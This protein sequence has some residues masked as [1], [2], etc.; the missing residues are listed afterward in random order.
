MPLNDGSPKDKSLCVL[1]VVNDYGDVVP[2][3]MMFDPQ[4]VAEA[5]M[6]MT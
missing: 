1:P 4:A 3:C 2:T 5:V 6:N